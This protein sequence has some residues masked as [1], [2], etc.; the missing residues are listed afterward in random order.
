V[1]QVP[2]FSKR[3]WVYAL[4]DGR[5]D[6]FSEIGKAYGRARLL[7]DHRAELERHNTSGH[8][9]RGAVLFRRKSM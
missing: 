7:F 5:T 8:Q 1:L 3:F 4:Y 9:C 2:D 6:E